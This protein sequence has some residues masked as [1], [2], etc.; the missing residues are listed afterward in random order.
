M[1]SLP[2]KYTQEECQTFLKDL[3]AEYVT[4]KLYKEAAVIL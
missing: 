4:K 3:K 2:S 1:K